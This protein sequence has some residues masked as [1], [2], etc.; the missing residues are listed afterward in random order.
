MARDSGRTRM[1]GDFWRERMARD[2][3]W[4]RLVADTERARVVANT[5][6]ARLH[7]NTGKE[8]MAADP[9]Q[10]WVVAKTGQTRL[11]TVPGRRGLAANP[12]RARLAANSRRTR[13]AGELW[14]ARLAANS[15]WVGMAADP[16]WARLVTDFRWER[17]VADAS[18]SSMA[19]Y[20]CGVC[21]GNNGRIRAH[22]K[23][24]TSTSPSHNCPHSQLIQQFKTLPDFLMFPAFLALRHRDHSDSALPEGF[25]PPDREIIRAMNAFTAFANE[26][27]EQSQSASHAL[28]YACQNWATHISRVPN[29]WD[30][31]LNHIFRT[32]WIHHLPYWLERQWCLKGLRSCLVVLSEGQKL[33]EVCAFLIRITK[34]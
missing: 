20:S 11:A 33:A 31:T 28:K 6:W 10:A 19:V 25:Y 21:L 18:W 16:R 12:R 24:S 3:G 27:Q 8:K 34:S 1:V 32:F 26:A 29:P 15:G 4:T 9:P 2:P 17:L 22:C 13:L 5:R 23:Q 7:E 30:A 14:R